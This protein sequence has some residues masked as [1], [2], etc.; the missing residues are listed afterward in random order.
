MKTVIFVAALMLSGCATNDVE[1]LANCRANTTCATSVP[2]SG[3]GPPHQAA[4]GSTT[5]QSPIR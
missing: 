5:G 3:Y 1:R 2:G 4:T